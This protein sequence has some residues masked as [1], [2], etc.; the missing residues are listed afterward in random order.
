[1]GFTTDG[2]VSV[3]TLHY[4]HTQKLISFK[5]SRPLW[6]VIMDDSAP[7]HKRRKLAKTFKNV[8]SQ[9]QTVAVGVF[10]ET[11]SKKDVR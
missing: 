2:P 6:P 10:G 7:T 11:Y 3:H 8:P 1:M 9:K 5:K 4:T